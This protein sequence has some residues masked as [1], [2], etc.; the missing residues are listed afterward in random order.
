MG[1]V[2]DFCV[3]ESAAVCYELSAICPF[4]VTMLP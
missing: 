1:F 4:L 3:M 2:S